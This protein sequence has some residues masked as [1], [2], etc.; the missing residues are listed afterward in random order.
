MAYGQIYRSTFQQIKAHSTTEWEIK[1][2]KEGYGGAITSFKTSKDSIVI[3]RDGD[4]RSHILPT[5]FEFS[6]ENES[7]GQFSD[8]AT[9]S[10]G[11]YQVLLVKDP[12]GTPENYYRGY[13][14]SEIYT[15]P[16]GDT[17]G[18]VYPSQLKFTCGLS[19]LKY[20]RWDNSGTIYTGQKALIEII[21]LATNK[22]PTALS[23][24]EFANIYESTQPATTIDSTL[25]HIFLDSELFKKMTKEEG[26]ANEESAYMAYDVINEICK[27]FRCHF[28]YAGD[29]WFM[30]RKQEYKDSTM[31]YREFLP[32]VGSESTITVDSVGNWTT[33]KKSV[34][35]LNNSIADIQFP[36][37]DAEKETVQPLNRAKV[38]FTQQSLDFQNNN[39]LK[40]GDFAMIEDP[41]TTSPITY[42]GFPKYWTEG[43]GVDYTTYFAC[44]NGTYGFIDPDTNKYYSVYQFNPTSYKSAVIYD[45]TK[46]IQYEKLG[47]QVGTA[48]TIQL[49]FNFFMHV[50][51]DE[52]VSGGFQWLIDY[53]NEAAKVTFE[54]QIKIGTYY[55][56]GDATNGYTWG[57]VAGNTKLEINGFGSWTDTSGGWFVDLFNL[58]LITPNLPE[59]GLR[60]VQFRI[61]QPYTDIPSWSTATSQ[62]SA[63]ILSLS[64]YD[65]ALNYLPS[66]LE[67]VNEQ[68]LYADVFE[69]E[70]YE[71]ISVIIGDSSNSVSQGALKISTGA[72]TIQWNR[73]GITE[74]IPI[75]EILLKSL[76][77]D[78][79]GFGEMVNGKLM[80]EFY[81]YN[82]ISMTVGAVT[83]HYL[84]QSYTQ[85]LERNEWDVSLFKLQTFVSS[86][87]VTD[88]TVINPPPTPTTLN[89]PAGGD[90]AARTT[91]TPT[92]NVGTTAPITV[93]SQTNLNNY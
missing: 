25:E 15:E 39:L 91:T 56:T 17:G 35:N 21:R 27:S 68:T 24:R 51:G 42:S 43:S 78:L 28:F 10:W 53:L 85:Y 14:Q 34:T 54:V 26:A 55:L 2:Y 50:E 75:L 73:R 79:G 20:V 6:V 4:L 88:S 60:D 32:R 63:E 44:G 47:I 37:A 65:V 7:E 90:P 92:V 16:F 87:T 33:N 83:T 80:G 22:I 77:D 81:G 84:I 45:A 30:I 86:L 69:D 3:R 72:N 89:P 52:L 11:D 59:S 36:A 5:T 76:R 19:H 61:Y 1:I 23:V 41:D 18:G 70:N 13:N 93:G 29:K 8:F 38:T 31:Y 74:N 9:A 64:I 67:P 66:G 57:T 82:T 62:A 71:E 12:N 46:Y 49:D 58:N 40:N 48:D